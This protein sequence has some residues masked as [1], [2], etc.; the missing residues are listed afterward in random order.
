MTKSPDIRHPSFLSLLLL[1]L[2]LPKACSE[3]NA[4]T[5]FPY[6]NYAFPSFTESNKNNFAISPGARVS[7][8]GALQITP[9]SIN[10]PETYLTNN[11]GRVFFKD[12]F[13]LWEDQGHPNR[14]VASF[15]TTFS[16][17][18]YRPNNA[19]PGEGLAF[20]ISPE[21][22]DPPPGSDGGYL[23]LTNANTDGNPSNNFVAVELDTV[24]ESY[25]KDPDDNHVGLNLNGV[26]SNITT[27][28][29]PL[30]I[31]IATRGKGTNYTVW[32]D[33]NGTARHISVYMAVRGRSKPNFTV[34]DA[35]IDISNYVKQWSYF[36]FS[37]STGVTYELNCV[38]DWNITIEKLPDDRDPG[39]WKWYLIGGLALM[40]LV[41][42]ML[43]W[44]VRSQRRK[45]VG[46]VDGRV[47]SDKLKSLPGMPREFK[48][49]TLKKATN[50]FDEKMKLGEGGFGEVYKGL[51]RPENVTVAVKKFSR[52]SSKGQDDFLAEL[53]II[54]CLRHKH[55]VPLL[56]W[57]HKNGVLLLVYEYMPNGSLDIHLLCGPNRPLLPWDRRYNI[58]TGVASSL[59]YLHYEYNQMVVHRD[60]KCSNIMLDSAFDAR[61]GDFG[62]ARALNTDKTSYTDLD[63]AGTTGY[64][65]PECLLTH[66]FTRE[67]DVHAFGAVILVVVC[68]RRPVFP[69]FQPLVDWVWRFHRDGRILDAVDPRLGSGY[70]PE[71]AERLLLLGLACSH[72]NP[73]DRPKTHAIVQIVSKSAPPP[74]V[75]TAKPAFVLPA[76]AIDEGDTSSRLT[77][78]AGA[79]SAGEWATQSL[80]LEARV[81]ESDISRVGRRPVFPNFQPLVDWVWRF[82]RDG[83][84]LDAVDPRLGS[85]YTPEDA[86]RLLLL[87]LACSHPNPADRPK[88]HAI[89]QIVSKSAPPPEVPTA[90]P[91]F[92]LPAEAIDEGDTSS[93]LTSTAGA[94]SA[95]EWATQSLSLEARVGESDISRV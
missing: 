6:E 10:Y 77:S 22:A 25:A 73:A 85:G 12:P 4:T 49:E 39:W 76:E 68:G 60:I 92:V 26:V 53:T 87:G 2:H 66:K 23:G 44:V 45:R 33:Y 78:T 88:T 19:T 9:D 56:G 14:Y 37:A 94:S 91:A 20:V 8:N 63:V 82:H 29:T 34:L 51:F 59:H 35:P 13:K 89:V 32:I 71:D 15:N 86:E 80:S 65:A 31:T 64:I 40:A 17:N 11:S 70:T 30:D 83:R 62:L 52:D 42:A 16:I 43:L 75:P 28:L 55:L 81:G 24:K 95:G 50:N 67:S 7:E 69:N 27:P 72:P 18:I 57:C 54:N 74:E 5:P 3:L 1:L 41:V 46:M 79:S 38:L 48:F 84:I 21:A 47:L 93:R 36:G 58:L 90:K 61:L